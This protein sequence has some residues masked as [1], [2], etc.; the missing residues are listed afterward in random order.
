MAAAPDYHALM[1]QALLELEQA[2]ARIAAL[3]L[4]RREPLAIVGAA[5]RLPGADDLEG[6][7][8]LLAAGR[9]AV[10]EVPEERWDLARWFDP[11]PEAP[12]KTAAR[13]GGFLRDIDSF[14]PRFFGIS[15]P[16]A[17]SLDPQQRLL[18]ETAWHALE[19]ACLTPEMLAGQRTGVFVGL[20]STDYGALILGADPAFVGPYDGTGNAPSLAA[21]RISYFLGLT[22]PCMTLDTACSSS[23]VAVHLA[24]QSLR[25]EECRVAFAGGVN[26]LLAPQLMVNFSKAGMLSRGG[27]CRAFDQGADG[28]VRAEGV[29]LIV[30]KRLRDALADGDRVRAVLRGTAVNT[31]G[32]SSG[33]TVPSGAAQQDVIR[34]A[35]EDAGVTAAEIGYV[36]AHGTGTA[37]GDPIE[38]GALGA[39]FGARPP[40]AP[41]LI[42]SIKSNI[43]HAE[44]AA[45]VA[46]VLK[47]MLALER[48]VLPPS[49]H[50]RVPNAHVDWDRL[51][52]RVVDSLRPWPA[53]PR[54][55]GVSAFGFS[56][57]NAHAVLEAAPA[58]APAADGETA[59]GARPAVLLAL[60]AR[61]ETSLRRL[62]AR[63]AARAGGLAAA[64]LAALC[65]E[66]YRRRAH[67]PSRLAVAAP[68]AAALAQALRAFAAG[69]APEAAERGQAG[70]PLPVAFLFSGQGSQYPGMGERLC[71]EEPLLRDHLE[72]CDACLRPLLGGSLRELMFA[73]GDRI[74]LTEVAQPALFALQTG[75][76]LLLEAWGVRAD[77]LLGCSAGEIAAAHA[78]GVL[79]LE[80]G[81]RLAA[82]RGRAMAA[83]SDRGAMAAVFAGPEQVAAA[84]A[85]YA[86]CLDVA[87]FNGPRQTVIAGDGAALAAALA[88]LAAAGVESRRLAVSRAFHSPLVEPA[89]ADLDR[90]LRRIAMAPPVRPLVS[91]LTGEAAGEEVG[92]PGYWLRQARQPVRFAAAVQHVLRD[93]PVLLV[94]VGPRPVL[95]GLAAAIAGPSGAVAVPTLRP[96]GRDALDL[97]RAL[98]RLWVHGVRFADRALGP[99]P[100]ARVELPRYPFQR[101]R[102]WLDEQRLAA[103]RE[104]PPTGVP[105]PRPAAAPGDA[106]PA[107]GVELVRLAWRPRPPAGDLP[108][109]PG[110]LAAA[111]DVLL[112][113]LA[114]AAGVE[115]YRGLVPWLEERS[116]RHVCQALRRLGWS[117]VPGETVSAEALAARLGVVPAQRRLFGRLLAILGE[118]A[119]LAPEGPAAWRVV[120]PLPEG[121][122]DVDA[123]LPALPA[124]SPERRLLE[125]CGASLAAVLAGGVEP[126][127]LLFPDGE[128]A[129]VQAVYRDAPGA[130]LMNGILERLAG[131]IARRAGRPLRVLEIGAGTGGAT[132]PVLA[133]LA[134]A[135]RPD[136]EDGTAVE[137]L[138]TD[139]SPL[140]VERAK[141]SFAGWWTKAG[142]AGR[143][144]V[145]CQVLDVEADPRAQGLTPGSFDL[146]IAANVLHAAR[147]LAPAIRHV[148]ELL[149]PGGL[150]LLQE[151]T[152]ALRW[153]DL[154][155][156]LTEGWW[157]F[158]DAPLRTGHPLLA[159]EAWRTLLAAQGFA[160]TAT[161]D[162]ARHGGGGELLR[163]AVVVARAG[164]EPA[165]RPAAAAGPGDVYLILGD[166]GGL[167]ARLAALLRAAGCRPVEV[168][169]EGAADPARPPGAPA[170]EPGAAWEAVRRDLGVPR[171]VINLASLDAAP[172][173][174]A[175]VEEARR[176]CSA[177]LALV[178]RLIAGDGGGQATTLYLVT[179]QAVA[180]APGDTVAGFAQA[181]MWGLGRVIPQEHPELPTV[182]IDLDSAGAAEEQGEEE[183]AAEAAALMRE[184][185]G[186]GGETQVALRSGARLVARL[187]RHPAAAMTSGAA[188]PPPRLSGDGVYLV[189][190]G[191][192]GL[193]LLAAEWLVR[194]GARDLLLVG[195]GAPGEA[196]RRQIERLEQAGARVR[197]ARADVAD[198][199]ALQGA[200]DL[201]EL[202]LRGVVHA[203]GVVDDA[204]LARMDWPRFAAVLAPKVA[205][206]WNLHRLTRR[207][208]LEL[209]VIFSSA[210][211]LLGNPG[212]SNHAA[213]NSFCAALAEHRR[214][215]GLPALCVDWGA[216]RRIG[217]AAARRLAG[218]PP[219]P[220]VTPIDPEQGLRI[221][222]TLLHQGAVH[223]GV[224]AVSW[225][226]FLAAL[227]GGTPPLLADLAAATAANQRPAAAA[228]AAA[229]TAGHHR[230]AAAARP[231]APA[232]GW[233]RRLRT[234]SPAARREAMLGYLSGQAAELLG[235]PAE[236]L[237][238]ERGVN[239]LG[240]DS[241]LAARL[242]SRVQH[243]LEV[244]LPLVELMEN[245][246]LRQLGERLCEQLEAVLGAAG[247]VPD[248]APE[249]TEPGEP[250]PLSWGQRALLFLHRTA[251]ASPAYNVRFAIALQPAPD[252][253]ALRA[254]IDLLGRRHPMLRVIFDLGG[255]EPRQRFS[256]SPP[257]LD[258][259]D[260][261]GLDEAAALRRQEADA[262]L[263]FHLERGP[264]CRLTLYRGPAPGEHV[265]QIV[266]HHIAFDFAALEIFATELRAA[267]RAL[268]RGEPAALAPPAATYRDY[269]LHEDRALAGA[270]AER[271]WRYWQGQLGGR[272]PVLELPTDG[273]RPER[274]TFAGATHAFLL[275]EAAT[276][277]L[278]ALARG[279]GSTLYTVLL[280]AYLV[281]LYRCGQQED[282][283]VGTPMSGRLDPRWEG[284]LGYFSNP[285]ALRVRLAGNP[286][287]R[288]LLAQVKATVLDATAH[289]DY[290]FPLLLERLRLARDP[291][292]PPL[293]QTTFVWDQ[294]SRRD[295][296]GRPGDPLF[297]SRFTSEQRGANF[298]LS[299]TIY[300]IGGP[301]RGA[302]SYNTDLFAAR[303]IARMARR[304][305]ELL[306]AVAAAPEARV[307]RIAL[308]AGPW[309]LDFPAA[310][311]VAVP[312]AGSR[313]AATPEDPAAGTADA[314]LAAVQAPLSYHQER[315]WFID[316][317]ETGIVYPSHPVYHN[318]PA[319]LEL[320][321]TPDPAALRR[322][323]RRLAD[324]HPALRTRVARAGGAPV[325]E[326]LPAF[327]PPLLVA[328]AQP[329][330]AAEAAA[331]RERYEPF[332]LERDPPWRA[333][334]LPLAGGGALL[335]LT[336]HHLIADLPSLDF[337]AGELVRCYDAARRGEDDGLPP[338]ASYLDFSRWQRA[339]DDQALEPLRFY[340]RHQLRGRLQ[341][342]VLPYDRP[343][344][345]TH[346]YTAAGCAVA[347]APGL[348]EALAALARRLDAPFEAVLLAGFAGILRRYSRQEEIVIGTS[349]PLRA[350]L[351]PPLVGP[352]AN[353]LVLRAEVSAATTTAGLVREVAALAAEARRHRHLPFDLLVSELD[354]PKDMSRTALFDVLFAYAAA[355]AALAAPRRGTA[356]RT[357]AETFGRGKYDLVLRVTAGPPEGDAGGEPAAAELLYNADLFDESTAA[358]LL[359]H[360][361]AL[362]A[363]M[364]AAAAAAGTMEALDPVDAIDVLSAPERRQQLD[365][366]S[367]RGGGPGPRETLHGRFAR[368]AASGPDRVAVVC[369]DARLSY[370]ELAARAHRL[371]RRLARRGVTPGSLVGLHLRRSP[372]LPVAVL[373]V[374]EAGAAYLPLDPA[375]PGPRLSFLLADSGAAA[376][377]TERAL[378]GDLPAGLPEAGAP[379]LLDEDLEPLPAAR[380][381]AADDG[382]RREPPAVVAGAAGDARQLAYCIYTSGST[383]RPKGVLLE[384]RNALRLWFNDRPRFDF[385]AADVWS[386]FHSFG[387]D[388][389]V[390]ETFGALLSGGTLVMV[391]EDVARDPVRFLELMARHQVTILSQTPSAFGV[392]AEEAL[393]RRPRLAVRTVVFGGEAL[394]PR[395]LLAWH[396][397]YPQARL[398]N[399]YGIT[400]T[401]VHVT[402][403]Q[404]DEP[405]MASAASLIGGPLP[406]TEVYVVDDALRLL[407]HG[408]AGELLVAGEGV[409][410][411]YL[412]RP[413][414]DRERFVDHPF[415]PG[416]RAYRSGDRVR[417][418]AGGEL[419]YLGRC[420]DQVQVRGFR[421][422]PGEVA[423]ALRTHPAVAE[424]FVTPRAAA[425]EGAG[426]ALVA[427]VVPRA[428]WREAERRLARAEREHPGAAWS[429]DELPNGM[430]IVRKN[431]SEVEFTYHEVFEQRTYLQHGIALDEGAVVVDVGANIGLFSL[432]AGLHWRG[433]RVFALEPV[434]ETFE[435]LR[436]NAGLYD[437]DIRPL[438]LGLAA[439][440]QEATFTYYPHVSIFS[441]RFADPERERGIIRAYIRN[442]S[443]GAGG[444]GGAPAPG[445]LDALLAERFVGTHVRCRL[446]TLSQLIAEHGLAIIDLLKIDAEKSE[447]D[448]LQGIADADWPKVR[449]IALELHDLDGRLER[450]RE[451]LAARGFHVRADREAL[452]A[453]TELVNVYAT[454]RSV[455]E[456]APPAT[457][458]SPAPAAQPGAAPPACSFF[459]AAHPLPTSPAALLPELRAHLR[460]ELP[461]YM[462][463]DAF[464][465]LDALPLTANGKVDRAALPPPHAA[466]A[467]AHVAPRSPT[468]RRLAELWCEVL[469]TERAGIDDN[470]FERGGHSL[471]AARLVMRVRDAFGVEL[472]IHQLFETPT[473]AGLAG[474]I[475]R[476]RQERE[477]PQRMAELLAR[478][479]EMSDDEAARLLAA[480][481]D[482]ERGAAD[483][484][485]SR[486]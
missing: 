296:P 93:G 262:D 92:T 188:G 121:L 326:V 479:E 67:L 159:A 239:E 206:L 44:G 171:A 308:D 468:E 8:D 442:R 132:A 148:R 235:F 328:A 176:P 314:G 187:Q 433:A 157:H 65:S 431:P 137:Y 228:A 415:R 4:S 344:P 422:E 244:Q 369:G 338:A 39:V 483:R 464:V 385:S 74:H 332:D 365:H 366:W 392:L 223:A 183:Q 58:A 184:L 21:G 281:L 71:A 266:G 196:A 88:A 210:V 451:L 216:W 321:A 142:F 107:G 454:R 240:L 463:P 37:L 34:R 405:A 212:Q 312:A 152:A 84:L 9:D 403:K 460:R 303:R 453:G 18:L 472:P 458:T 298:D 319:V 274:Q 282:L 219:M 215:H 147:R 24:A 139:V 133:G 295:P 324:R 444:E 10:T 466:P 327:D 225:G 408:V 473:I 25:R 352:V 280:T 351:A 362:L 19:D 263:P 331:R 163:Q 411:G 166:G 156:G 136:G 31:D 309:Q 368:C 22:G 316:L 424:V 441:G 60:S 470:F 268:S 165:L 412:N 112:P 170:E 47:A 436:I 110:E 361:Q 111:L 270:E 77:V 1:K 86:G 109:H 387:F 189:A 149:A 76:A 461:E 434:P 260:L 379:I 126:L 134:A 269:V 213:A 302:L 277:G 201:L 113:G 395:R 259:V 420:D 168:P 381:G 186:G 173:P 313:E 124:D 108:V 155:F 7:W 413:E 238:A 254:A 393:R 151:G 432:F 236:T 348:A 486:Q 40:S 248:G 427:Y 402:C 400:E 129:D 374:L 257:G 97:A 398:F 75:L 102:C 193:G 336:V 396:R 391:E 209:F 341:P 38:A 359:D 222:E 79:S 439:T 125:R 334:L 83:T 307:D 384:H 46:G 208:P 6:L 177:T 180:A 305:A 357:R 68:D 117:P 418:L 203:A 287:F 417:W 106:G 485:E 455:A 63:Y 356:C 120:R 141:A 290:P 237:D 33:L 367:G 465:L 3:E 425:A 255:A 329:R 101:E 234:A 482:G 373:G 288:D 475:G 299:L 388:F 158:A 416:E 301:L 50:F 200:L 52:L 456:V 421:V 285:V 17:S 28:Y 350:A 440:P 231:S 377:I 23:L 104:A 214:A 249:S 330:A 43:G 375:L 345:A 226:Q 140:F 192:G 378:A 14:D 175:P 452:L 128:M 450:V 98:G 80:D 310:S 191:L 342:L 241:L 227:P 333:A 49:L 15:A 179:R 291:A 95:V 471:L 105:A 29:G 323:L 250:F 62:A 469:G 73:G 339:L 70:R 426:D 218:R 409:A 437:A 144:G 146:V 246:S 194:C 59:A 318:L 245:H 457:P 35:L 135:R 276:A 474:P 380:Q 340:W 353:L 435:M 390:W 122:P 447:W 449:Q 224:L 66:A 30:L 202:P 261:A 143:P 478:L 371:A 283:L 355:P 78:A 410:R 289:Q 100:A 448:I 430:L 211:G 347:I 161:V 154:T 55:A 438:N 462:L 53:G 349:D 190:G 346:T 96:G 85:P 199:Q 247:A 41:L 267:Y 370:R 69:E 279:A 160:A 446:T 90:E 484:E 2:R 12:G 174:A 150:L 197:L 72:R 181:P 414:L 56:G 343:R 220:G 399:L 99:P 294:Q 172:R 354:P 94:E 54:R 265:L 386:G 42:G 467:I 204:S 27:R 131:E 51:P 169:L 419:L 13:H 114:A 360:W 127:E 45:G 20:C 407:P 286:S 322:A 233:P 272:L 459:T 389:S 363:G 423:H 300:D 87:A 335:A 217:A 167:G 271:S 445:D 251:P 406:L 325:Q 258:V 178:Q 48:G 273:A 278:R 404:I 394:D 5:C 153:L 229:G 64:P 320:A 243:D 198:P 207:Q 372:W 317:F 185:F 57:T 232:P 284:I 145:R 481:A 311:A 32:R 383:G 36:E 230:P 315:L 264:I 123:A 382:D 253:D 401:G 256:G 293:V 376:L 26:A 306:A 275:D 118:I 428:G 397:A 119:V 182:L 116:L 337:A 292:R 82:V 476:L 297:T 11:D 89:L 304:Y 429:R 61:G 221:L 195:R 358:R 242:R 477:P 164:A 443:A 103:L 115:T 480:R 130:R 205:G 91:T 138:F 364:A 252:L 81:L 162:P 16:E